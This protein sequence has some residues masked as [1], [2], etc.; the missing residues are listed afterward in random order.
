[1]AQEEMERDDSEG[2]VGATTNDNAAPPVRK[3]LQET[4][5]FFP[6]IKT[7]QAGDFVLS[8]TTPEALTAWKWMGIAHTKD[9]KIGSLLEE[10]VTQKDLMVFP[11]PPRF[12]RER[13]VIWFSAKVSNLAKKALTGTAKLEL[14]D[15]LTMKPIDAKLG[16]TTLEQAINLKAEQSDAVS[17]K[18]TIPE[19]VQVVTWRVT[20][21]AGNFADGEENTLPVLSNRQLVTESMP[22]PIRGKETKQFTFENLKKAD[23]SNTLAHQQMTLEFTSQPAWYAIQAL[24]YLMEFPHQCTEQ[25]FSRYYA[26]SIASHIANSD[27]RIKKVFDSWKEES[28]TAAKSGDPANSGAL[29]SNL[30]KN[31]DLKSLLLEET[32]WVMA[33]KNENERKHRLAVLFDLDRMS[34]ELK[35]IEKELQ[36]RQASNGGWSWFPGMDQSWYITQHIVANFGHLQKLGVKRD[37]SVE[38]MLNRAVSFID[39]E[40]FK[41]YKDLKRNDRLDKEYFDQMGG[42]Y[43]YARSFF[44]AIPIQNN[45]Q[46]AV[47]YFLKNNTEYWTKTG[48]YTQAMAAISLHRWKNGDSQAAKD[49]MEAFRQNAV[50]NEEMGMYYKAN[51]GGWYW[52]NAP[53]ETQALIIEAFDEVEDDLATMNELR[54]WLLK[55]KQTQDWKTTKATVEACYALLLRGTNWLSSEDLVDITIGSQNIDPKN[56]PEIAVEAGTGYFKTQWAADKITPDMANI[57]VSKKDES[58]GWGA[59]YW[60]YF[61]DLDKITRAETPLSI[62][63]ELFKEV[64]TKNGPKLDKL[65]DGAE[66]EVGDKVKVRIVIRVDRKMEYVHLKD[67]RAAGFEPINVISR[68]KYQDGLGYYEST[69]DASTNFF[70]DHLPKGTYVFEYPL[71]VSQ[72][73]DFSNGI[74]TM[75]CMYAPEF[76]SHSEGIRVKVK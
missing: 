60:Q 67:M 11:N 32:P 44:K 71:R 52:Y 64:N 45:H 49:I 7:N 37:R 5:F 56:M 9:L 6:E 50:Q 47:D 74:T 48:L 3:N 72:K 1:M 14:F 68:Y 21:K 16:N 73:G 69:K 13:D 70:M 23:Q 26:N 12:F 42:H 27:P 66:L 25:I 53:I 62:E 36:E 28:V 38:N 17:W 18:L 15:A 63:K 40:M 46:E 24:P 4:A 39:Q 30:Q 35:T 41:Y 19:G 59:V 10:T 29:L 65:S 31:Q 20:A 57:T 55:Q 22:L 2:N 75:Q 8:F 34:G 54:I 76:T 58:I 51:V 33:A 43:L 61:E